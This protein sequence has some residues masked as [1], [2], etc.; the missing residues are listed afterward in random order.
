[1]LT[2]E[3]NPPQVV[4]CPC[5]GQSS[6]HLVRYVRRNGDAHA[7]Y[8]ARFS[9]GHV[10]E[11]IVGLISLG[12]WGGK[13]SRPENRVAIAFR[14][15]VADGQPQVRILDVAETPWKASAYFGRPLTRQEALSHPS[16]PEVF[17]I[18]DHMTLQDEVVQE[19]LRAA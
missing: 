19:Y 11:G 7:A 4:P 9:T 6:T 1:M 17:H 16:L 5:C 2:I 8:L 18:T 3:F 13:D 14:L 15:W 12:E 10:A